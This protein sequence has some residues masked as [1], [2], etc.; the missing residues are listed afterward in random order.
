MQQ[1]KKREKR[2]Y[3]KEEIKLSLYADDMIIYIE[4]FKESTPKRPKLLEL[5]TECSKMAKFKRNIQKF[6][7]CIPAM[8]IWVEKF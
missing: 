1:C 4:N 6:Y 5:I 8:N 7:F 3:R 2:T